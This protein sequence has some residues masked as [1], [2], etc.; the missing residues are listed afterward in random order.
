MQREPGEK[1]LEQAINNVAI[2]I[3]QKYT[4]PG[5]DFQDIKQEIALEYI[6]KRDKFDS[7]KGDLQTF[8]FTISK[9]KIFNLHR[10]LVKR[11][12]KPCYNCPLKCYN[13]K[14]DSCTKYTSDIMECDIY[15]RWQKRNESKKNIASPVDIGAINDQDEKNTRIKD[16]SIENLEKAEI[17]EMIDENLPIDMRKDYVIFM[18]GG[19]LTSAREKALLKKIKD[20]FNG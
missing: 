20:I 8:I 12:D 18:N 2:Q 19:N 1:E 13:K 3:S 5:Y 17:K 7:S 15:A 9:N 14:D 16:K 6:A 4:I 11:L 10:Y